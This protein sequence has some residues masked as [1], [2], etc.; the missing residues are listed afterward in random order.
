[1]KTVAGILTAICLSLVA[2]VAF[3][4][5][6]PNMDIDDARSQKL[7][8]EEPDG[9][10]KALKEEAKEYAEKINAKRKKVYEEVAAKTNTTPEIAGQRAHKQIMEK[11]KNK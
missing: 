8:S 7:V 2:A 5:V 6:D 11:Q 9:T 4:K 3:A 10:V 1:M